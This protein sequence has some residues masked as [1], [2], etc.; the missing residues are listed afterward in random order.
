MLTEPELVA[1]W[2]MDNDIAPLVGHD[3]TFRARPMPM[4]DGLVNC[5]VR[6][7]KP[8][9][10]LVYSWIGAP[11]MPETIV[12][13][14]IGPATSGI[15]LVLNHSG[16]RGLKYGLIGR[17]LKRG[18]QDMVGRKLPAALARHMAAEAA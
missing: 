4:W 1:Q 11:D 12:S 2:L 9:E 16:F 7:V 3:F 18:W 14:S 15:R 10:L 8:A 13:W 5:R 6:E 17:F